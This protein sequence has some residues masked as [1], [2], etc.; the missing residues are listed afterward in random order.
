MT[1]DLDLIRPLGIDAQASAATTPR[2]CCGE[3]VQ[4]CRQAC[5]SLC[6]S[7]NREGGPWQESS[8]SSKTSVASTGSI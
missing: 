8:R 4:G 2:W 3:P 6:I 7:V 1:D 5:Y